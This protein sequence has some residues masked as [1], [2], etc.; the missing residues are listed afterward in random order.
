ML[1]KTRGKKIHSVWRSRNRFLFKFI[2]IP[3]ICSIEGSQHAVF[4]TFDR[5]MVRGKL[6]FVYIER[7]MCA[8]NPRMILK[9]NGKEEGRP[10]TQQ[11][12]ALINQPF[13]HF[14]EYHS[15]PKVYTNTIK[16]VD[17]HFRRHRQKKKHTQTQYFVIL[18]GTSTYTTLLMNKITIFRVRGSMIRYYIEK[19]R[20][21]LCVALDT[22]PRRQTNTYPF[23]PLSSGPKMIYIYLYDK[24]IYKGKNKP[25]VSLPRGGKTA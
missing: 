13:N 23:G 22:T 5:H 8:R 14:P 10:K 7:H 17:R 9:S 16:I 21:R 25:V 20:A 24:G 19:F 1:S 4:D 18:F 11:A 15:N 6:F 12:I 3:N 2:H